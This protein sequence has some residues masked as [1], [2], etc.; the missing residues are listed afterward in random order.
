MG[1]IMNYIE[2]VEK[3]INY[4]ENKLKGTLSLDELAKEFYTTK[5]HFSRIFKAVTGISVIDYYRR[6]KFTEEHK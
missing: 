3:S 2:I 1:G 6:R 4:I 5:F